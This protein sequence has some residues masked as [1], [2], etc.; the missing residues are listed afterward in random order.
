[1]DTVRRKYLLALSAHTQR[2]VIA[3]YSGYLQKPGI[4]QTQISDEDKNGIMTCVHT[5]DRTQGLDLIIHTEGGNIAATQSLVHYLQQ[6]FEKDVRAI[7]PQ[8]AMSAGT[9][10]ACCTKSIVMGKQSNLGPIDPHIAG[11]PTK[12]VIQ[13]FDTALKEIKSDPAKIHIWQPILSQYRPTFL[14]QC[15]NA[16]RWSNRFVRQQLSRNMFRGVRGKKAKIDKIIRALT[17][18]QKG[19]A[20]HLHLD[21]CIRIGLKIEKLEDD[22]VFQDLALTCHHGFMHAFTNTT[23]MKIIENQNGVAFV[24]HH[25]Q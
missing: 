16:L 25:R 19:H 9:I 11:I 14:G 15:E 18:Y 6:M 4:L 20:H 22:P 8:I 5:L 10:V 7:V 1:M 12:G 21:D 23:A 13:E 2:N 24:K 3:Y 17:N